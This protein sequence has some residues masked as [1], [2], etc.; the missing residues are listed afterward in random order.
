MKNILKQMSAYS[1]MLF[2]TVEGVQVFAN[3]SEKPKEPTVEAQG[4]I[5]IDE[6]SGRV[7][8][9]HN[10]F[11]PLA[12]ASTTKI[13]TLVVALENGNLEDIVTVSSKAAS[14]PK[15]KMNL[16]PGE[17][18]KLEYLLFAL[19]LQ[20]FN[21][22]AVAIAEHIGGTVEDFCKMMTDKAI[23][24]GAYNTIFETPSGLDKGE[25]HSTA[26]DMAIISR[27]AMQ[28][29]EFLRIITTM[30]A[31]VESNKKSYSL[32]N[33]NRLLYEL[34]GAKGVKTGF[35]N[36]A[37]HCFVGAV[38]HNEI[39]FISV[40]LGSGWGGNR[41]QK[42]IDTKKIL[43][44]G[45]DNFKYRDIITEID[46]GGTVQVERSR[47]NQ[48][49]LIFEETLSLP[50]SDYEFENVKIIFETPELIK[51]PIEA[52][53]KL[54]ISKIYIDNKLEYEIDLLASESIE[55]HDLK[56]SIEKILNT[57]FSFAGEG[58]IVLPEWKSE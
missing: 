23:E 2:M 58:N 28:N 10:G 45:F 31:N 39:G 50:L 47:L 56:T 17:E 29:P 53:Q 38:D 34:P 54:G 40:V 1:I 8:W 37:G 9:E 24:I 4:A 35:T 16:S 19:M 18:I 20:S 49:G 14:Q 32:V 5:L 27:Y 13:M 52:N 57:W 42:W 36:K 7:L 26:Y 41:Q 51:A 3:T 30:N 25:H 48:V 22:S 21:D 11:D 46:T 43:N 6:A 44:Y 55:R 33:K 15:V 12:M